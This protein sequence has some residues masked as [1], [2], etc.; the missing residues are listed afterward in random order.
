M[1]TKSCRS[2]AWLVC[3]EVRLLQRAL[4]NLVGLRRQVGGAVGTKAVVKLHRRF[5]GINLDPGIPRINRLREFWLLLMYS[6]HAWLQVYCLG[7]KVRM[8]GA[9][10]GG[11]NL[12][13]NNV[14]AAS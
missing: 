5:V 14:R 9:L 1:E 12:D 3:S 6:S 4:A 7:L 2:G 13:Y 10:S 8:N 11:L